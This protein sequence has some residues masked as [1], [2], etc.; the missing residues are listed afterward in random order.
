MEMPMGAPIQTA[1]D[2]TAF[3]LP[4][5]LRTPCTG[6]NVHSKQEKNIKSLKFRKNHI[7]GAEFHAEHDGTVLFLPKTSFSISFLHKT[8]KMTLF[9]H[10]WRLFL[11]SV[12][13]FVP[14][15]F[16]FP[17]SSDGCAHV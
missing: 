13:Y 17:C 1:F 2:Y 10:F 4:T 5:V 15:F 7:L 11:F 8:P 9:G 3:H 14:D 16:V 6:K 12:H